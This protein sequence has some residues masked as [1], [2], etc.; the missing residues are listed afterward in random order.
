[1]F[2]SVDGDDDVRCKL[3]AVMNGNNRGSHLLF[4]CVCLCCVQAV[5]TAT[6]WFASA[7]DKRISRKTKEMK[8][9]IVLDL[10]LLR[11]T[12]AHTHAHTHIVLN[13]KPVQSHTIMYNNSAETPRNMFSAYILSFY[14]VHKRHEVSFTTTMVQIVWF[15]L[16]STLRTTTTRNDNLCILHISPSKRLHKWQPNG[17]TTDLPRCHNKGSS[18]I[19]HKS[20]ASNFKR[21]FVVSWWKV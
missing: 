3:S 6:H 13:R 10:V 21:Q 14:E 12:L 4:C 2:I 20:A 15:P 5:E 11:R 9:V 16:L 1:M 8:K 19:S 17:M 7:N 18:R